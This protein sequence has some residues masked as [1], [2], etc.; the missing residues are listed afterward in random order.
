MT[1]EDS[2]SKLLSLINNELEKGTDK[3]DVVEIFVDG[4]IERHKAEGLV[5]IVSR[6]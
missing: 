3:D 6:T 1:Q 4:G 5:K 2:L